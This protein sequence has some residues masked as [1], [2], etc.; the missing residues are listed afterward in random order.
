MKNKATIV[1]E[2]ITA[3]IHEAETI[4]VF[5]TQTAATLWADRAT[6]ITDVKAVP[7]ERFIAW[8][9]FKG[10]SIRSSQQK[11]NSIPSALRTIFANMLIAQNAREPFLR[12]IIVPEYAE[13]ASGFSDW[14]ADLLPSLALWKKHFEKNNSSPDDE[15]RDLLELYERYSKFL[16][17]HNLFDPAW[18]TPPF[19]D[20]G[21]NYIIFFPEILM[22]YI[23]YAEILSSSD[24]IKIIS[25]PEEAE[26]S[27]VYGYRTSRDELK[28][29]ALYLR[30]KHDEEKIEWQ[31]IAVNVPDLDTYAPYIERELS[32]F[33]IP[34]VRK[35]GKAYSATRAGSLFNVAQN[36]V[37]RN[38][39]YE[40]VK[41]LLLNTAVPWKS[42]NLIQ[43]LIQFG[44]ENNCI[45][46]YE[47][48]GRPHDT[49][50]D[51]FARPKEKGVNELVRNY[52]RMLK[53]HVEAMVN[54][55][56]FYDIRQKYFEFRE[57]F[58]DME[59]FEESSN[60]IISR[61][62]SELSTLIDLETSY[63]D[64]TLSSPYSFFVNYLSQKMYVPQTKKSGVQILPY[65]LAAAAPFKCHAVID[66]S[67]SGVSITYQ[68]LA[69]LNEEKRRH[70]N[71]KDETDVSPLFLRLYALNA[72]ES[73]YFSFAEKTFSSYSLEHS[74]LEKKEGLNLENNFY[75]E[76]KEILLQKEGKSKLSVATEKQKQSF[77]NWLSIQSLHSG[78]ETE[79]ARKIL[80][81]QVQKK[82][83]KNGRIRI[84][85][86]T[87][88]HFLECPRK[89]LLSSAL[90]VR[91]ENNEATL[92]DAFAT[93]NLYHDILHKYLETLKE[94]G[95]PL[96]ALADSLPP[97][98]EELLVKSVDLVLKDFKASS[99]ARDALQV[100][101]ESITKFIREAVL[102]FSLA[103]GE[104]FVA[105]TE[106]E[107]TLEFPQKNYFF[108]GKIDCLLCDRTSGQY[109]LIDFKATE[110]AI[111][112]GRFFVTED[113]P[114][115]NFQMAIYHYILEHGTNPRTVEN[116]A[117]FS[118]KEGNLRPVIGCGARDNNSLEQTEEVL[119]SFAD[120]FAERI[121]NLQFEPDEN[122]NVWETCPSCPYMA[123]CRK[124]FTVAGE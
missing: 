75:R 83:I 74:A 64:C 68:Q 103:V 43:E 52:Y 39:S 97:E 94:K 63:P 113:V 122:L 123:A 104:C 73:I 51:S 23:E 47:K 54:A 16:E 1:E 70:L 110:N 49:W 69:F 100:Q 18:E 96:Q 4:F 99:I 86:T 40:S 36:C 90:Y 32:L 98:H 27:P 38:F 117:F 81:A 102:K 92:M 78:L 87:L 26:K 62:I 91:E 115:P 35:N 76:E 8:D 120:D 93:G 84:S 95:I 12:N 114:V 11:K 121:E 22:D 46:A 3:H 124:T 44:K 25:V 105:E 30:K 57:T 10:S 80:K 82:I 107:H 67:Q 45:C 71:I 15:D 58:F 53:K 118:V 112:K 101:K 72:S 37:A 106:C 24:T 34:F 5:P 65:R 56:T 9:D 31:E 59:N 6:L 21:K 19:K 28:Q 14:I 88:N 55:G 89:W 77:E 33:E 2:T 7:L 85:P 79:S 17:S 41:R 109:T 29:L 50:E 66:A 42:P 60:L 116:C 108:Y 61:C 119:L 20:E 111:P 13:N 48:D